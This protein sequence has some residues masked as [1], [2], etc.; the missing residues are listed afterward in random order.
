MGIL[1]K[2]V[3]GMAGRSRKAPMLSNVPPQENYN[4]YTHL[5]NLPMGTDGDYRPNPYRMHAPFVPLRGKEKLINNAGVHYFD[6]ADQN[7]L[8][9]PDQEL[10][11]RWNEKKPL[12][13]VEIL[14]PAHGVVVPT[15]QYQRGHYQAFVPDPGMRPVLSGVAP[16]VPLS[17]PLQVRQGVEETRRKPIKGQAP[18]VKRSY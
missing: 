7:V 9:V 11:R 8:R 10:Q 5:P 14:V 6:E 4:E 2:L 1:Q 13:P 15:A 16:V 12:P 17:T 3:Q 18:K